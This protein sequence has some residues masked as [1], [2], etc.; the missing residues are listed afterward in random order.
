MAESS[1]HEK[2]SNV[3]DPAG[4]PRPPPTDPV[5]TDPLQYGESES[6]LSS[7]D[8]EK[9]TLPKTT[10]TLTQ[11]TTTSSLTVESQ[12]PFPEGHKPWY[13]RL[14]PLKSRRKPPVPNKRTVSKEY[15]ASFLSKLTFQWMSPIMKVKRPL[16]L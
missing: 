16:R 4:A 7:S 15:G 11:M 13:E 9:E 8:P 1:S 14:N 10:R 3:A 2:D 5:T 6:D 12:R